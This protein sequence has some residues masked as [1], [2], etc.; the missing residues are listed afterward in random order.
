MKMM[1]VTTAT[2]WSSWYLWLFIE[3]TIIAV[4]CFVMGAIFQLYSWS[5]QF[6]IF[7]WLE[8]FTINIAC[9]GTLFSCF[10]DNPKIAALA[11]FLVFFALMQLPLFFPN[12]SA[13]EKTGLCLLGPSCFHLSTNSLAQYEQYQLGLQWD[14]IGEEWLNFSFDTALLMLFFDSVIYVVLTL[15]F[16]KV[17]PSRYGQRL[18]PLFFASKAFWCPQQAQNDVLDMTNS[19]KESFLHRQMSKYEELS[20]EEQY[21]HDNRLIK[22]RGLKKHFSSLFDFSKSGQVVKAVDGVSLDMY[23]GEVFCLLGHNGAGKTTTI[24]MLTGL[25]P[26]TEGDAMINGHPVTT[27]MGEIRKNLGVC[28]QHDVLFRRLTSEEHL[29]LFAR[30]KGV[31]EKYIQNEVERTLIQVGIMEKRKSFPHQ[32]SGGQRRKL[33]LGIALIGGSK[34]VFLDEPT[35]GM[36]PQSRRV[37]WNMIAKEK[38]NRCIILTTHFMD[39]ADILGDRVAVMADGQVQ[40]CGSPLFLKRQYGV[41]YTFTVSLNIDVDDSTQTKEQIDDIVLKTVPRSECVANAS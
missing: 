5:N 7:L 2:Y 31:P 10:F 25:L 11:A 26:V 36:D 29:K 17:W 27:Q 33:S 39:E 34:I 9:L 18:H 37:T 28:P 38:K 13:S 8:L 6:I 3:A 16:D 40:C 30:L 14:N 23:K 1:G 12:A 19:P 22:V 21:G 35:S 15:Y 32:M 20:G 24:G 41:G 4:L